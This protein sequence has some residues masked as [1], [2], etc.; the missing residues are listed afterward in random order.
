MEDFNVMV[1]EVEAHEVFD[2]D[3]DN[4][5]T[6]VVTDSVKLYLQEVGKIPLLSQEEEQELAR[7]IAEGDK[8]AVS[9]L[10]EHNLRLVVSIAKKYCGCGLSFLDL[11]QEGNIGLMKA[12]EKYDGDRGFKFSTYATWWVRQSISRA[13]GDQSRTIRVPANI[14]NLMSKIKKV[15]GSLTQSLGRT[16]TDQEIAD[17]LQV[18]LEKVHLAQDMS[19]AI[20][21]L[22]TPIGDE[23]EDTIGDLIADDSAENPLADLITQANKAII[24]Q[25]FTTLS[26]RE[27]EI[28]RRR[29]GMDGYQPHTLEQ[30]GEHYGLTRERIR[31]LE[32]KALRK[33]RHPARL[34][35]L[36]EAL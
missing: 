36:R 22:D 23:E 17:A 21:S 1:D 18:D 5:T 16:P 25:V 35:L 28:L 29:F 3:M 33:L 14:I 7:R 2:V 31:Q 11:I 9:K 4:D 10:A 15:S 19:H 27:A 12:A 24:E 6:E 8:T 26:K 13:L 20:T 32:I 30:V 34:K